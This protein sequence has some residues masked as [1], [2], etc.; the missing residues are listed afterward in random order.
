MRIRNRL[1]AAFISMTV[2]PLLL[3]LCCITFI[4][5]KQADRWQKTYHITNCEHKNYTFFTNPLGFFYRITDPDYNEMKDL[6]LEN[7][8]QLLDRSLLTQKNNALAKQNSYL[9]IMKKANYYF[10][11]SPEKSKQLTPLPIASR[12]HEESENLTYFDQKGTSIVREITFQFQDGSLGQMILVFDLSKMK[13]HW[14]RSIRDIF[15]ALFIVLFASAFVLTAWIYQ[16][17]VRPLNLLRL[18]T[19]QLG[20]GNLGSPV[21]IPSGDEIGELGNDFE[22]MRIRLKNM[23]NEWLHYEEN[24]REIMSSISHDLKT[25]ITAIKGYTEGI[26]D[27]VADTEE[28]RTRY[29]QTIYAKANDITYLIDELSLYSK[30]EQ[31]ALAYNFLP[32]NLESYFSDCLEDFSLDLESSNITIEYY[33]TTD[34]DTQVLIDPEQ[35]KRVL[36]NIIGNAVKYMAAPEGHISIRI[37]DMPEKP[38]NPPLFRQI[39]PDGT[40]RYP[41]RHLD[42]FVRIEIEDNGPGIPEEDLPHIFERFYRGDSSRNSSRGGS[43]LGLAIVKMII[44]DHG[45]EVGADSIVGTGTRFHFTLKKVEQ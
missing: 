15:I 10:N 42:N 5:N 36:Q 1:L 25:P 11:G 8:D 29:L 13:F 22:E 41:A 28:K 20:E 19:K 38:V 32:I 37:E 24:M 43:G 33:N 7:P 23:V 18:A 21:R 45:G 16:S 27:G 3:T 40:D 2:F 34:R 4:L 12:Q 6:I 44:S 31:N 14:I 26:L 35:I 39:N 9:I 30:V 17:I